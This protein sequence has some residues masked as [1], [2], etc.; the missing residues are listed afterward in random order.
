MLNFDFLEK[1]LVLVLPPHFV[2]DFSKE[3]EKCCSCDI[4]LT[5]QISLPE[6]L[7]FLSY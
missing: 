4:L 5:D 6:C 3:S 7:Y 1:H 2:Y